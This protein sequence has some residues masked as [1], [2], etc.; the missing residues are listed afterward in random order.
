MQFDGTGLWR[1]TLKT[2]FLQ[3]VQAPHAWS[4]LNVYMQVQP[5]AYNLH[6]ELQA[7]DFYIEAVYGQ[8]YH[9]TTKLN[10]ED[11]EFVRIP[12]VFSSCT[13]SHGPNLLHS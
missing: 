3:M 9:P 6:F 13:V 5:V 8:S 10:Y 7:S 4:E 11:G 1:D 12:T 2:S